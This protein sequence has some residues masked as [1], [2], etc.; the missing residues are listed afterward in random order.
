M[1]NRKIDYERV[2]FFRQAGYTI[3]S[4]SKILNCSYRQIERIVGKFKIKRG[5]EKKRI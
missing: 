2:V 5:K 1:G 4:I 3:E